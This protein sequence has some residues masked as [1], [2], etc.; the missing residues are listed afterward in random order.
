MSPISRN[1]RDYRDSVRKPTSAE[2]GEDMLLPEEQLLA[3]LDQVVAAKGAHLRSPRSANS[4]SSPCVSIPRLVRGARE[5]DWSDHERLHLG[6]CPVCRRT[7]ALAA[8]LNRAEDS[9][10]PAPD[11][12]VRGGRPER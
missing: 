2:R 8:R 10:A 11:V 5:G 3:R 4:P 9:G 1:C 12:E 6:G 7:L